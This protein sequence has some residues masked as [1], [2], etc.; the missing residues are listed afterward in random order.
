MP[1]IILS[2]LSFVLPDGSPLLTDLSLTFGPQRIGLVGRNGCG[3]TTLLRLI[4]GDLR[5][6]AGAVHVDGQLGWL[7]QA[8]APAPGA[9]IATLC[10]AEERLALLDR[11]EAGLGDADDL[12]RA[13]WMLPARL[14][15]ALARVGLAMPP[16]TPL[17]ALSG[18]QI[19]RARLAAL[20]LNAPDI[21]LLDEPTN[22]LDAEGRAAVGDLLHGWRGGAVVV[23]HDRKL[24][25]Q[26]D[27]I[28]ELTPQGVRLYGGGYDLWQAARMREREAATQ[29]LELAQRGVV[30]ARREAQAAAA[31]QDRRDRAGQRARA[32]GGQSKMVLDA[33]KA[34]AEATAGAHSQQG[35]AREAAAGATLA[36]AQSR[37]EVTAPLRMDLPP[38]VLP[39]GRLVLRLTGLCGGPDPVHPLIR[40]LSLALTGPERLAITGPNGS[41]KTTL[42]RLIAG[43]LP[44]SAGRIERPVP[45]ALLDQQVALLDPATSL[46]ANFDRLHPGA[47]TQAGAAAL[48]QFG[49]RAG[50][51]LR[52]AGALSGGQRL[53]AGLACTLG[54]PQPPA[55]LLLDEPT[56]HLD[57]DSLEALEAALAGYDG[58]LIV[59]SHDAA[60]LDRLG[61][62]RR[63]VLGQPATRSTILPT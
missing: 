18:G 43:D 30:A 11:A 61:L 21:L 24:L 14:A 12:T 50:D 10:R 22:N 36:A 39:A 27:Q 20:I 3:K 32:R 28:V 52:R 48:A 44:A 51:A 8:L 2:H 49:F 25:A 41:G 38:T 55:L 15:A 45:L 19:S 29:A 63:L 26:M 53:R 37:V 17:G 59:V 7:E 62:T 40:N 23:S 35:A 13:D 31:R 1:E 47:G 34:R 46:R 42:L 57:L 58:A 5:P 9:T 4:A 60:F 56:N 6:T 54:A 16:A 33:A